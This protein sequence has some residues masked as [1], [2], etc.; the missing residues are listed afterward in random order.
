MQNI[1]SG[2]RLKIDTVTQSKTGFCPNTGAALPLTAAEQS[3]RRPLAVGKA[4]VYA[5]VGKLSLRLQ[6]K[7]H[8]IAFSDNAFRHKR[9]VAAFDRSRPTFGFVAFHMVFIIDAVFETL[10]LQPAVQIRTR[11]FIAQLMPRSINTPP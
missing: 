1:K 2:E 10:V 9:V 3:D 4:A 8:I 5:Q 6:V 7:P 11:L